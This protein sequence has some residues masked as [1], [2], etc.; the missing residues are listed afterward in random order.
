[1]SQPLSRGDKIGIIFDQLVSSS[2]FLR[3][4]FEFLSV[5]F[6][7]LF[8]FGRVGPK[9]TAS[10]P[11]FSSQAKRD[12]Y[13]SKPGQ[14]GQN[15]ALPF[16]AIPVSPKPTSFIPSHSIRPI[17]SINPTSFPC[18]VAAG[19]RTIQFLVFL[20][21]AFNSYLWCLLS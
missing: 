8:G 12:F 1:M 10:F 11:S 15:R 18:F 14:S 4:L 7:L 3:S 21:S 19:H 17:L 2:F 13:H 5:L 9:S 16:Q 20:S 6:V